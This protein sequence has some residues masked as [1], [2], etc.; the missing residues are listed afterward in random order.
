MNPPLRTQTDRDALLEGILDGIVDMIATDH[1][2]H[3]AQEKGQALPGAPWASS[4]SDGVPILYTH[5]VRTGVLTLDKLVELMA[6]K[7]QKAPAFPLRAD[8]YAVWDLTH[9]IT[10]TRRSF[11]LHGKEHAL[12]RTDGLRAVRAQRLRR[13]RRLAG[14]T[15]LSA[16]HLHTKYITYTEPFY[17]L[18]EEIM[19]KR[20]DLEE[21][22]DYRLRRSSSV[23]PL[24]L[25]MPAR[26]RACRSRRRGTKSFSST[27]TLPRS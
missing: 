12:R 15:G 18:E 26:R 21:N 27:P 24:S 11:L 1:A 25:T 4:A 13:R 6:V 16:L 19:P 22:Y 23:G 5:L 3:S 20:T 17:V 7:P 2:P 8:D 14:R 9:T 10:S